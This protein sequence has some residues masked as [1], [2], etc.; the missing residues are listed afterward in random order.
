MIDKKTKIICTIGPAS[1][2]VAVMKSMIENGMNS[3]RVNGAFADAAEL[4]KV[5]KIIRS[6]SSDVSLILDVKGP[7]IRLNKFANA[8]D[9]KPG[10]RITIGDD[11]VFIANYNDTHKYISPGQKIAVGDGDV[12]LI[13]EEIIE[14][15]I[16]CTV[17]TGEVLKPGK[18][19]NFPNV[20]I[21][22]E[23]LTEKDIKNIEAAVN[24]KY[25]FISASFIQDAKSALE[26][27]SKI[28]NTGLK[29]IA[30]IENQEG[31]NNIDEILEVVDG[32]MIARGGLGV[33]LGLEKVP[34]AQR[35][36]TGRA[37]FF[38][39]PVITATQ[40]LESMT[41]S[42]IP[43]RAEINDVATAVILGSDAVMLSGETSTGEYP[44]EAVKQMA[45]V[46][47]E[48]EKTI[49]KH[50]ISSLN[51]PVLNSSLNELAIKLKTITESNLDLGS[52][53]VLDTNGEFSRYLSYTG[54]N[55]PIYF[56]VPTAEISRSLTLSRGNNI[57]YPIYLESQNFSVKEKINLVL[58]KVKEFNLETAKH[59]VVIVDEETIEIID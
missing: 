31:I 15:Q 11:S 16:I 59:V 24:L 4:E 50:N 9:I 6:I 49:A 32:I 38:A 13:V 42:P 26:I 53:L 47:V 27:A 25:D 36:L 28:K 43:T 33:E 23:I 45:Q 37:I 44:A 48:T 3:A 55:I 2:D 8:I 57:A 18:A 14:K 20:V 51:N 35:F 46:I 5:A 30:K 22:R 56:F 7:E 52:I 54:I 58:A 29:L 41:Y 39:K 12:I 34:I 10:D 19:L 21:E 17:V 40:M 1:W